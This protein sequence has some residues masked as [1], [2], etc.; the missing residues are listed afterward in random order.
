MPIRVKEGKK[1]KNWW[2]GCVHERLKTEGSEEGFT[3]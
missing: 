3:E 2:E 1:K